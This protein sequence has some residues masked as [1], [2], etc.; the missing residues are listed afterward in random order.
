[1][2]RISPNLHVRALTTEAAAGQRYIASGPVLWMAEIVET[3]RRECPSSARRV[4]RRRL[5]DWLVRLSAFFVPVTRSC[6]FE[7]GKYRS[8]SGTKAFRDFGWEPRP[9]ATTIRDTVASLERSK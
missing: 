9:A 8:V 4:P 5:P 6:L 7:L 1:M 2:A 3:I